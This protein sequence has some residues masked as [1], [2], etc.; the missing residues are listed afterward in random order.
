MADINSRSSDFK[1]SSRLSPTISH[2]AF[3]N[4]HT[5][6]YSFK[7]KHFDIKH[8]NNKT[9]SKRGNSSCQI[10]QHSV[11][12]SPLSGTQERWRFAS[13]DRFKRSKSIRY[14]RTLS[15]GKH[16]EPQTDAQP[17]R[18]YG[19][20]GSKRR[21]PDSRRSRTV[22]TLPKIR[23]AGSGISISSPTVRAVYSP[24]GFHEIVKTGYNISAHTQ[25]SSS[26]L[27]RRY[28]HCRLRYNNV[29][30]TN[31]SSVR[32]FTKPGFHNKLRKVCPDSFSHHGVFR[33]TSRFQ[34]HDVLST[35]T[36]GDKSDN[37][38]PHTTSKQSYLA[39]RPCSITGVP[40]I[41]AS[42][43][44]AGTASFQTS[45]VLFDP[46]A[47]LEPRLLRQS[48]L[49]PPASKGRATMVDCQ[50]PSGQ[51]QSTTPTILRNDHNIGRVKAGL[52]RCM[53]PSNNQGQL[54]RTGTITTHKRARAQG[55]LLSNPILSKAQIKHVNK[56]AARQYNCSRLC[57]QQGG[58]TFT[59]TRGTDPGVM[60]VVSEQ[61]YLH[62]SSSSARNTELPGGQRVENMHRPQ[63]LEDSPKPHQTVPFRQG[64]RP[65]RYEADAPVTTLCELAPGSSGHCG[66]CIFSKLGNFKRVRLPPVQS[67]TTNFTQSNEGR[68]HHRPSGASVAGTDLVALATS[69][70]NQPASSPAIYTGD[71]EEPC[72]PNNDTSDV[73]TL[74]SSRLDSF[75]RSCSTVGLPEHVT[76]LLSA[77]VRKSTSKTYDSSWRRWNGWCDR[78]EIDP[79]SAGVNNVLTFLSEQFQNNLQYRTVNVLRSAISS[80]HQLIDGKPIGQHPLV[81]RLM[82]GISNERP[83]RPRY[84]VTWDVSKVT[85]Y[86][87]SLGDN[88]TLS[89]KQLTKKLVMLLALIS[90]ERSSVLT[91]LD[92]RFLQKQPDGF[93]FILTKPRKTGDPTVES[94]VSFPSLPEDPSLC[95]LECLNA[96]LSATKAFR[97]SPG[98]QK[99]FLSFQKPHKEIT[100]CT[101]ARW[102]CDVIQAAGI[103]SSV[104]KAHSTRAASTSS[105]AKHNLPL[106]DILKMG[107]W[108]S[109]ST[110]QKF[111]YKPVI[112]SRY[113]RTVL[114]KTMA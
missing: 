77:S 53:R 111:Y 74:T 83:P 10:H 43:N 54:V 66:R 16:F 38:M 32:S 24:K 15:D 8:R 33:T 112:D 68:S 64:H 31:K 62:S 28:S 67:N 41:N 84:N 48:H 93:T 9:F 19:K 108:S 97:L 114:N 95:P 18:F 94:S 44:M 79:I 35:V 23:M 21:L 76:R 72:R 52:G 107:D 87:S 96:Y 20:V 58:H 34:D 69:T 80:T 90:P 92:T 49:S 29:T 5:H 22:S 51:R 3:T 13:S 73:P 2:A 100:R 99:L 63:R 78:R 110:F 104:F 98:H 113:A 65:F 86:L 36:Q 6:D 39:T 61:G 106:G 109:P 91:D 71:T 88:K 105:A 14:K 1:Y 50:Y 7:R 40:R 85:S 26:D 25:H 27:S 45:S 47:S 75:Q 42:R 59:R 17:K 89:L 103:D 46:T 57:E 101:V 81:V 37:T 12:Q 4:S 102:L 30:R 82:K 56:I 60:E 70:G 55:S 11:L